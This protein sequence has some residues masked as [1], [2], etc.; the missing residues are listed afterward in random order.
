[1]WGWI[2]DKA[3]SLWNGVKGIGS[4]LGSLIKGIIHHLIGAIFEIPSLF[5]RRLMIPKKLRLRVIILLK[6]DSHLDTLRPI[7][8]RAH[9]EGA[10]EVAKEIYKKQA[11]VRIVGANG[12]IVRLSS[13]VAPD[14]VLNPPCADKT[15]YVTAQF[16]RVGA[17]FRHRRAFNL[18][19]WLGYGTPLTV[20]I[21]DQVAGRGGCAVIGLLGDYAYVGR[22]WIEPSTTN[23]GDRVTLAHEMGHVCDLIRHYSTSTENVMHANSTSP[24]RRKFSRWQRYV[25]RGGS[26]VTCF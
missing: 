7:A 20:F 5:W 21:V 25:I 10:V 11:N 6:E 17:W 15:D 26:H 23:P 8:D 2:K 9:V 12:P 3:E 22:D 13:E 4:L 14:Y 19:S 1:M 18:G 24:P 16:G